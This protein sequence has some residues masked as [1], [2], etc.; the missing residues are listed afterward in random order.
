[1]NQMVMKMDL[2]VTEAPSPQG[3]PVVIRET[4]WKE[5]KGRNT[6]RKSIKK[7]KVAL[8]KSSNMN[9]T[10]YNLSET[11]SGTNKYSKFETSSEEE[12]EA[13]EVKSHSGSPIDT[14]KSQNGADTDG[15][16]TGNEEA[17]SPAPGEKSFFF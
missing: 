3:Q 4:Q 2:I 10:F 11:F 5:Q 14:L 6:E 8:K 15:E 16:E 9:L 7:T 13:E 17:P 12:S 1:M